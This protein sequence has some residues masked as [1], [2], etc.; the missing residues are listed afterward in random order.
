MQMALAHFAE[1]RPPGLVLI[2]PGVEVAKARATGSPVEPGN[3]KKAKRQARK[4][5]AAK[6]Q[7]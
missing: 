1:A 5:Q 4:E 6:A 7:P 2:S 3:A